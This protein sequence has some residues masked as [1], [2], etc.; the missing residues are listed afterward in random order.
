LS[1][2]ENIGDGLNFK[3][4]ESTMK[5]IKSTALNY[6]ATTNT[7]YDPSEPE[8]IVTQ[9]PDMPQRRSSGDEHPEHRQ[10]QEGRLNRL[11]RNWREAAM[12][13]VPVVIMSKTI[14]FRTKGL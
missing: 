4:E 2:K 11:R 14:R 10:I 5:I 7:E 8:A 12:A 3:G 1:R 13:D 9:S 6:A